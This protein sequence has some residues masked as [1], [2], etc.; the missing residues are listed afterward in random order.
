VIDFMN[1]KIKPT[2][3]YEGAHRGRMCV[4]TFIGVSARTCMSIT[5]FQKK[6]VIRTADCVQLTLHF[7]EMIL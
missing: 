2:Q 4:R 7:V 5:V 6:K 3:S 1:L